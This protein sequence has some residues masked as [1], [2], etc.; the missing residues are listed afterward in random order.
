MSE[1]V[2]IKEPEPR[3]K[4]LMIIYEVL[5]DLSINEDA[6]KRFE[7]LVEKGMHKVDFD[8]VTHARTIEAQENFRMLAQDIRDRLHGVK[9]VV[10]VEDIENSLSTLCPIYPIC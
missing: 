1:A 2:M 9:S 5:A 3:E 10:E 8:R 4:L 7:N 6:E